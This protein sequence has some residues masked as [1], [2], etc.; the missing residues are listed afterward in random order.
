VNPAPLVEIVAP[1]ILTV[2]TVATQLFATRNLSGYSLLLISAANDDAAN[3]FDLHVESG[4]WS[5]A[6]DAEWI[7]VLTVPP[8]AAGLAGQRT[9][10]VGPDHLRSFFRCWGIAT[11]GNVSA[12]FRLRGLVRPRPSP[13]GAY[14]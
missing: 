10:I 8:A 3:S 14:R 2:Q 5:D 6:L 11:G 12:R 7:P 4:E 1:T 9:L 13:H